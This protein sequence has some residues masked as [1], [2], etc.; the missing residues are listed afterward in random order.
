MNKTYEDDQL[1]KCEKASEPIAEY[2]V[3]NN[4]PVSI[5]KESVVQDTTLSGDELLHKFRPM[6]KELFR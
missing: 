6:L 5:Q 4:T 2:R 1:G 3:T